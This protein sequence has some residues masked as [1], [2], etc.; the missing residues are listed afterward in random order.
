M[1]IEQAIKQSKPFKNAHTKV[2]VNLVYSFMWIRDKQKEY[3]KPFD[4]TMQQYN[5][6]RILRGAESPISTSEIKDR[7]LDRA[8]DA[9]RVVD[10]LEKKKLVVKGTCASDQRKIDVSINE[11]G[12]KLL[13]QIDKGLDVWQKNLIN[14][15]AKEANQLSD[16]L[17]KLRN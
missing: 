3:F 1:N 17:D 5:I 4:I 9:S 6:L 14:L 11:Q 7:M 13:K 15:T 16:L 2:I 8:S 10:R 12:V